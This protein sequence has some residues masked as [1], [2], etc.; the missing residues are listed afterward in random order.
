MIVIHTDGSSWPNPGPGGWAAI[1][2]QPG[3]EEQVITGSEK[4]TTNNRMEIIA[5]ARGLQQIQEPSD[6]KIYSD[7]QYVVNTIGCWKDGK[8]LEE[9]A[10]VGWMVKWKAL[11]WK[12]KA[13]KGKLEEVKNVDLWQEIDGL[14]RQH[15]SI[16]LVWIRGHNDNEL[17]ER[18]D[19]LALEA[20]VNAC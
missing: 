1:I 12:K 20:R 9:S 8:P 4:H 18:C 7:S 2:Q 17:N 14:V 16:E 15:K 10:L 13:W 3:K 19:K 11:G 5:V 6:I